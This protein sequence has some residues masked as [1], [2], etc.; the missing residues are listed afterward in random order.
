MPVV[1]ITCVVAVIDDPVESP[2]N[3]PCMHKTY[4][5]FSVT[6][7]DLTVFLGNEVPDND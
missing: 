1:A 6:E 2:S 5:S 3:V 7:K 4:V